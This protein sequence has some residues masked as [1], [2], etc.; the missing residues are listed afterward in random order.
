MCSKKI[1]IR[2]RI[3]SQYKNLL[4]CSPECQRNLRIEASKAQRG[5]SKP[6]RANSD[7]T[8]T[9]TTDLHQ[10]ADA[11]VLLQ[12]YRRTGDKQLRAEAA[13]IFSGEEI[14]FF[15][16]RWTSFHCGAE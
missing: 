7:D 2:G 14:N 1:P 10:R 4:I 6:R 13:K 9:M 3:P 12:R 5:K 8:E 15:L 16:S 11:I